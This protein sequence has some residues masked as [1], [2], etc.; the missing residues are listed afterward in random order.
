[1]PRTKRQPEDPDP[2]SFRHPPLRSRA[3]NTAPAENGLVARGREEQPDVAGG[4][5]AVAI[6]YVSDDSGKES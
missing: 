5:V 1:M 3:A 6:P 4:P 2:V